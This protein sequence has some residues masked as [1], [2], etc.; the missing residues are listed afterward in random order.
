MEKKSPLS[1]KILV[2][3][4]TLILLVSTAYRA[5]LA[6]ELYTVDR[7]EYGMPP[8]VSSFGK[9]LLKSKDTDIVTDT[10]KLTCI[11]MPVT[12]FLFF[13]NIF[14]SVLF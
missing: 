13:L 8:M 10:P 12:F 11:V 1:V 7:E 14:S 6:L 5:H 4:F 9:F 3:L 2:A